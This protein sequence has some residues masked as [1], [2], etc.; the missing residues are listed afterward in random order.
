MRW[1][2]DC[3]LIFMPQNKVL[4]S[5]QYEKQ[6]T[7]NSQVWNWFP[8]REKGFSEETMDVH[9]GF[10]LPLQS[11]LF[12]TE[13]RKWKGRLL[14]LKQKRNFRF[15][16]LLLCVCSYFDAF[17]KNTKT[18]S[19]C[20]IL[21]GWMSHNRN[22]TWILNILWNPLDLKWLSLHEIKLINWCSSIK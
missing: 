17:I 8:H 12:R 10:H 6:W 3:R 7:S 16:C 13:S 20:I 18:I 14:T 9:S 22:E 19:V 5:F 15:V 1:T 21:V 2:P 4:I 11:S